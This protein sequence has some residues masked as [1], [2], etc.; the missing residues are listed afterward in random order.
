L[1]A[2]G[3]TEAPLDPPAVAEVP[4]WAAVELVVAVAV[5]EAAEAEGAG[6]GDKRNV[7]G[8]KTNEIKIK[9]HDFVEDFSGCFCDPYL[10]FVRP[11]RAGGA[12]G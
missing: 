7:D 4:A 8:E 3:L 1:V 10:L 9:Y 12:N 2:V 11:R 6:A 5:A